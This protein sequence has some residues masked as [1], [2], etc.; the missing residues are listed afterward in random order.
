M[1]AGCSDAVAWAFTTL[2][3]FL[4]AYHAISVRVAHVLIS[5]VPAVAAAWDDHLTPA[6]WCRAAVLDA[7]DNQDSGGEDGGDDPD[8]GIATWFLT[9]LAMLGSPGRRTSSAKH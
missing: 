9:L 8:S 2:G 5:G 7:L 1:A 4:F 3:T 6:A